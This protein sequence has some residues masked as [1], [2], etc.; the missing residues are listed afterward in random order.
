[1][2]DPPLQNLEHIRMCFSVL[3]KV[4]QAESRNKGVS[5]LYNTIRL[6]KT[7]NNK[8]FKISD[9][10]QSILLLER[11]ISSRTIGY[12]ME[13]RD[14]IRK[15][16]KFFSM[17]NYLYNKK[18]KFSVKRDESFAHSEMYKMSQYGKYFTIKFVCDDSGFYKFAYDHTKVRYRTV[19][20]HLN[21][22]SK[23][24][25]SSSNQSSSSDDEKSNG[26]DKKKYNGSD[27]QKSHS[28]SY[29]D[30]AHHFR[31]FFSQ[32]KKKY[33]TSSKP[34]TS[35]SQTRHDFFDS[36]SFDFGNIFSSPT[37]D[38]TDDLF[39]KRSGGQYYFTKP[40]VP[41]PTYK[42]CY[43]FDQKSHYS[44]LADNQHL[45]D[46]EDLDFIQHSIKDNKTY[47]KPQLRRLLL[48]YHP[49][50]NPVYAKVS[51]MLINK[52]RQ[53]LKKCIIM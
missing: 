46:K 32:Y 36:Q 2:Q 26:S 1:M 17:V 45:F 52:C 14:Y 11:A 8:Y 28:E 48:K 35:S 43:G 51:A 25:S 50:K 53:M 30:F 49:D 31:E 16:V 19:L 5:D 40:S 9:M 39:P 4:D 22:N 18:S 23:N 6:N 47:T 27:K 7:I 37:T 29:E 15:Q 12:N 42:F 24:K 44:V 34:S 10:V 38:N 13:T 21:S 33:S 20:S 3:L 41:F